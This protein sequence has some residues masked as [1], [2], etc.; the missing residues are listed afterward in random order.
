MALVDPSQQQPGQNPEPANP[1]YQYL[2]YGPPGQPPAQPP[3][4]ARRTNGLAIAALVTSLVGLVTGIAAPVGAVL[5]HLASRQIATTGEEGASMA[6]AAIWVGWVVTALY[7]IACCAVLSLII[8]V[9]RSGQ[10]Q[11]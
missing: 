4:G 6:K 3:L 2:P 7:V 11:Q 10:F 9:G 8:A 5:G 1:S